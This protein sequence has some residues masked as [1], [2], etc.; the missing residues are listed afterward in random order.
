VPDTGVDPDALT[1]SPD[2]RSVYVVNSVTGENTVAQYSAEQDGSVTPEN[3][4]TVLARGDAR[5][6]EPLRD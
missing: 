1:V 2:S 5:R 4:P 3:P 6:P